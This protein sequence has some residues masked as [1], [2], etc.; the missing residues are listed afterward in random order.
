MECHGLA[1]TLTVTARGAHRRQ[2]LEGRLGPTQSGAM[3]E[4]DAANYL[5]VSAAALRAWRA[6]GDGPAYYKLSKSVRYRLADLDAWLERRRVPETRS[7]V[8]RN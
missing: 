6:R 4:H 8:T 1:A 3:F 2:T 5:G 7:T